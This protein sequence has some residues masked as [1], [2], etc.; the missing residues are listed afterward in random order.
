M[1]PGVVSAITAVFTAIGTW[2]VGA[3]TSMEAVF[4]VDGALTFIGTLSVVGLAI[5][6]VLMVLAMIRSYLQ[7]RA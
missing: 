3:I 2:L 4:W 7:L 1:M 5:A 6:V